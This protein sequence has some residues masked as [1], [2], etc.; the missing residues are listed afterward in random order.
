VKVRLCC[1]AAEPAF[2]E[3]NET[4]VSV[5]SNPDQVGVGLK[6]NGFEFFDLQS[7]LLLSRPKASAGEDAFEAMARRDGIGAHPSPAAHVPDRKMPTLSFASRCRLAVVT[8][9]AFSRVF[10]SC[11]YP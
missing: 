7:S 11:S 4:I 10:Q 3:A 6:T 5:D 2:A 9:V 1:G 8:R